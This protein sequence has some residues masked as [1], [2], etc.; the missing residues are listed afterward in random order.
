MVQRVGKISRSFI[1]K[2]LF[3]SPMELSIFGR[4]RPASNSHEKDGPRKSCD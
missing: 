4:L 1:H 3:L 2:L